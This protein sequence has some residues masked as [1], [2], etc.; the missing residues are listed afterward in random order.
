MDQPNAAIEFYKSINH[1]FDTNIQCC[2]ARVL[3][4]I[5][6][7]QESS[8]IYTKVLAVDPSNVEALAS[9]AAEYY[10]GGHAERA[11]LLYR[12]LLQIGVDQAEVWA[13]L[14]VC[15]FYAGMDCSRTF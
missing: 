1:P 6:K 9:L 7:S 10:D 15:S 11:I 14:G 13:N 3:R 5:N 2:M 12:R 8:A 4:A